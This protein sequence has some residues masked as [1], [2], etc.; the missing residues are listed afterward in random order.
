MRLLGRLS[1]FLFFFALEELLHPHGHARRLN[2]VMLMMRWGI[3]VEQ[4]RRV[5]QSPS[6]P[7]TCTFHETFTARLFFFY[8]LIPKFLTQ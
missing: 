2:E 3:S 4:A 6:S 7:S 1:N 5:H 8:Y